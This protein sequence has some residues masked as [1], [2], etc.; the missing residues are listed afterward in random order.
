MN[1]EPNIEAAI[2]EAQLLA[3]GAKLWARYD[4]QGMPTNEAARVVRGCEYI[5]Y[6]LGGVLDADTRIATGTIA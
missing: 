4:K 5:A 2:K 1:R 3:N 6:A